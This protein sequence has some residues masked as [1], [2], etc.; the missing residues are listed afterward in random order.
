M[1]PQDLEVCAGQ[2]AAGGVQPVGNRACQRARGHAQQVLIKEVVN[3]ANIFM[4][5]AE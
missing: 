1:Y 5:C 2:R 3:L 4:S